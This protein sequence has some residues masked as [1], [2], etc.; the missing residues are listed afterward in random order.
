[1][2]KYLL[3]KQLKEEENSSSTQEPKLLSLP[4]LEPN[5]ARIY[6]THNIRDVNRMGLSNNAVDAIQNN[7]RNLEDPADGKHSAVDQSFEPPFSWESGRRLAK[8]APLNLPGIDELCQSPNGKGLRFSTMRHS[9][10]YDNH[11]NEDGV[12]GDALQAPIL[13]PNLSWTSFALME[14]NSLIILCLTC[15]PPM[16]IGN[17]EDRYA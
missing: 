1:M 2:P 6:F 5:T 17:A 4:K 15:L 8:Y 7:K 16:A 13:E 11:I 9:H 14:G 10:E 12:F 3:Q